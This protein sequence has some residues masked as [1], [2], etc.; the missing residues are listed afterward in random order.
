MIIHFNKQN[1]KAVL[2]QGPRHFRF[3]VVVQSS[4]VCPYLLFLKYYL[5]SVFV[6]SNNLKIATLWQEYVQ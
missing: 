1:L 4:S 6:L 5:F 3:L 2:F